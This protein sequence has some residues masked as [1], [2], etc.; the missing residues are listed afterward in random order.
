MEPAI[1]TDARR[2]RVFD[3]TLRDGE[4]S[5]GA[6]MSLDEKLEVA[7][8]LAELGVD[9]IEA[10]FPI[11]SPGD[12]AAVKQIAAQARG[13]TIAALARCV[14]A[15][16]DAA[17]EALRP[18]ADPMLHVFFSTSDIHL[19]HQVRLSREQAL[20]RIDQM[21]RYARNAVPNVEWSAM[22]ATR[23][24]LDYLCRA[25]EVAVRAGATTINLPDTVGYTLPHECARMFTRVR[26]YL[27]ERVPNADA[28]VFSTHNHDDLG[29][30][31]ANTIAAIEAGVRQ[32]E[33]TINGIGERAG[34]TPLEEVV[35]ALRTRADHYS[36][37][38]TGIRTERIGAVSSLVGR[39]TGIV[40]APN[41]AVVG[42]N[43]FAHESGIHQDGVIKDRTT[44]E[45]MTAESVGWTA[46][47]LVMGKHSG[48]AGFRQRLVD[49]GYEVE[50]DHLQALYTRFIALTD[51]KKRIDDADIVALVEEEQQRSEAEAFTLL[52]WR[53]AS[54]S[55]GQS[56][57]DAAVVLSIDGREYEASGTGNG[58]VDA[59]FAAVNHLVRIPNTL[60]SYQ[61]EAV[62]PGGD[63]Q[64]AVAVT[65]AVGDRTFQGRGVATDVVEASVRAY[66]VALNRA[67]TAAKAPAA[68]RADETAGV[69]S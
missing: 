2:I 68:Q 54:A 12:L 69:V 64:G 15:D 58:Q 30:A 29:M 37:F 9:V 43:A 22:D 10:G 67:A 21:V 55:D 8:A 61:I 63:A 27:A 24:D 4:Q 28:I 6:T 59:L 26:A 1:T 49:L 57:A 18:A 41:K 50:P 47:R 51:R 66:I 36:G 32:I 13:V 25:V 52:A 60:V 35:M 31:T 39:C 33:V 53:S 46:D 14:K 45:I 16:I 40:V 20:E 62:T 48:R 7:T 38:T 42:S 44:Y 65:I 56:R 11:A 23:T 5:P 34:N 3:T 19:Q 17:V